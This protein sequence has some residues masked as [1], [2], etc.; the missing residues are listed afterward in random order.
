MAQAAATQSQSYAGEKVL[1]DADS[2]IMETKDWLVGFADPKVRDQIKPLYLGAA[3]AAADKAIDAAVE[4]TKDADATKALEDNVIGGPKGWAALGAFDVAE[5]KRVLDL[6]GFQAQLVFATF[7]GTQY[8]Y[9]KDPMVKYGGARAHNRGMV[10][11]CDDPR[12]LGVGS[13]PLDDPDLALA[14]AKEAIDMGIKAIWV[15]AAPAGDKSPGHP[16]FDAFW[17]LLAE[18]GVPFMLHIGQGTR[19]L[20]KGYNNTGRPRPTDFLGGGENIRIKDYM[21]L[22][23]APEMFLTAMV[24]DGVFQRHPTLRGGVIELG[25]SWVPDFLTRMDLGAK[26]F[27][28]T[29]PMI[30]EMDLKPSDYIRRA[31]RFTPFPSEDTG[32]IIRAGGDDLFLFSS[33]YPHPEG[34]RDPL[35]RF[36]TSMDDA[37]ISEDARQKFYADNFRYMMGL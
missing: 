1:Y 18:A 8:L 4:R 22:G 37:G 25:A 9:E 3:G 27:G 21:V 19:I 6:L 17:A 28:K 10:A 36:T 11:F 23:M 31:V 14:E 29:D 24:F 33:D 20:P 12:M 2:H 16:D 5:R 34:G 26:T 13:V 15:P 30:Q 35:G 7:C 32:A